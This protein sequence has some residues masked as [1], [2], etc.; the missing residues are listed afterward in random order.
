MAKEKKKQKGAN[1][2][3]GSN[4]ANNNAGAGGANAKKNGGAQ[5]KGNP[6]QF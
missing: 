3:A 6:D 2:N 4:N 5:N 1:N